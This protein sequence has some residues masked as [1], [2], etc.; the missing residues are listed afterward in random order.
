MNVSFHNSILV[1]IDQQKNSAGK[2]IPQQDYVEKGNITTAS[3]LKLYLAVVADGGGKVVPEQAAKLAV[4]TV[5]FECKRGKENNPVNILRNAL[6][7]A[8]Q[9]VYQST[10]GA[11][12]AG[13]TVIAVKDDSFYIGQVGRLTGA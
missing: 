6:S 5:F 9:A 3:G 8:N 1:D 13:I 10:H 4:E 11:D 12:Y 7:A 2:N